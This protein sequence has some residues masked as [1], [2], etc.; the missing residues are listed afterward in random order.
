MRGS[1]GVD[2]IADVVAN[3]QD[4]CPER[5]GCVRGTLPVMVFVSEPQNHP[6]LQIAGL[7][8]F[9]PQNPMVWF[10]RE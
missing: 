5:G 1:G 10:R 2:H 7:A 3:W 6:T 9:G 8:G 4:M